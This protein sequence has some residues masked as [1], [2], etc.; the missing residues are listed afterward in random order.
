MEY[1]EASMRALEPLLPGAARAFP[2]LTSYYSLSHG[3]NACARVPSAQWKE[4]TRPLLVNAGLGG[5]GTTFVACLAKLLGLRIVHYSVGLFGCTKGLH[6]GQPFLDCT[7]QWD[8][9]HA[10]YVTDTPVASQLYELLRTHTTAGIVLTLRDPAQWLPARLRKHATERAPDWI[11][12]SPCASPTAHTLGHADAVTDVLVY[13]TWA[14]CV[15]TRRPWRQRTDSDS[16]DVALVNLFNQKQTQTGQ[17]L[18]HFFQTHMP[19]FDRDTLTDKGACA[20]RALNGSDPGVFTR[21][22]RTCHAYVKK[23]GW[24]RGKDAACA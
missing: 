13:Q 16:P 15:A 10:Q 14:H 9:T 20:G 21:L 2:N 11:V 8:K 23:G 7:Q 5:T 3:G 22:T 1:F 24:P 17:T 19:L 4:S 6:S 18:R 12:E